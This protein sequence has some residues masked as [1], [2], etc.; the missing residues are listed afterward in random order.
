M[1]RKE[2]PLLSLVFNILIPVFILHRSGHWF[3]PK[4]ALWGLALALSFPVVYG[5]RDFIL[6]RQTNFVSI[7]GAIN[8]TLTGSLAVLH[9]TGGWF[10]IKEAALPF[11]LAS[12]VLISSFT[13]K[14]FAKS[15]FINPQILKVDVLERALLEKG[16]VRDFENLLRRGT[17]YFSMSFLVSGTLNSIL[18]LQVFTTIDPLLAED[19]QS[20]ILNEQIAHMTWLSMA[21]I[22]APLVLFTSLFLFW[23]FRQIRN[24]TG[25][26]MDELTAD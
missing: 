2:H 17:R 22:A 19:Q 20:Q 7:L 8:A 13:D 25:L 5:T 23:F 4:G 9:L 12:Y 6:Y 14:P 24:L 11:C 21:V 18:A 3:G 1:P 10:A 16:R 26:T 15:F